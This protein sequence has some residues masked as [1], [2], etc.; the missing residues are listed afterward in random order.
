[1]KDTKRILISSTDVMMYLFLLP[2]VKKLANSYQIDVA[3]SSADEYKS[4]VMREVI[5]S[6]LP[7]L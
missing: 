5:R 1:M 2:H 7:K 6:E 3:C 4:E